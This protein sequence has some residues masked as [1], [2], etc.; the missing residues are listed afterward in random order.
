VVS[1]PHN[2]H[3]AREDHWH[4]AEMRLTCEIPR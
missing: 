3:H 1:N 2:F 4:K